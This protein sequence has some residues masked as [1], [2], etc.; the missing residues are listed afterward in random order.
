MRD[1]LLQNTIHAGMLRVIRRLN[2][3]AKEY[4]EHKKLLELLKRRDEG[5]LKSFSPFRALSKKG[6][7]EN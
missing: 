1:K 3:A 4:R 2:A 5:Y 6:L 7:D